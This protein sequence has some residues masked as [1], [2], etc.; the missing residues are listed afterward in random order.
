M[1]VRILPLELTASLWMKGYLS[2]TPTECAAEAERILKKAL[3]LE[4]HPNDQETMSDEHLRR[5]HYRQMR[6]FARA[7]VYATLANKKNE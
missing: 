4:I 3:D 6:I 2:V 1:W 7:L 5:Y